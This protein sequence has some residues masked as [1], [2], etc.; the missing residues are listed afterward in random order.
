MRQRRYGRPVLAL[1][2][3]IGIGVSGAGCGAN[4]SAVGPTGSATPTPSA[5]PTAP[6]DPV[7]RPGRSALANLQFF[8]F[9]NSKFAATNGMSDGRSIVDNLVA[10]GFVKK[11][12]EVTPDE[13]SIGLA[14]DSIIVSV[15]IESSCLI[16]QFAASGYT[17]TLA[18]VL[19]TGR[20][21]VG[22]TR[23]INW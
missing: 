7:L 15:R 11:D 17:D 8:T 13:T 20:C 10:A 23:R 3:A 6:P 14:A 22:T 1:A 2:I 21:L 4:G 18:P 9:V 12:M 19:G 16:G 5:T